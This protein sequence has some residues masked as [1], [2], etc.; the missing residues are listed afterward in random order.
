MK[1]QRELSLG[2]EN[3]KFSAVF[4][5]PQWR[6]CCGKGHQQENTAVKIKK[7]PNEPILR[8]S[9]SFDFQQHTEFHRKKS[10]E[11]EPIFGPISRRFGRHPE[12]QS[13]RISLP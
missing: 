8:F 3:R 11:N 12:I 9:Q 10:Q 4:C 2:R 13:S 7:L 1:R 6:C 5:L